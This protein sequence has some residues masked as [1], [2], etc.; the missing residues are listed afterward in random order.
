MTTG[1]NVVNG[2]FAGRVAVNSGARLNDFGI[3]NSLNCTAANA[4]D[5]NFIVQNDLVRPL[6]PSSTSLYSSHSH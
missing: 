3:G 1:V 2:Q 6:Q 5:F 4:T